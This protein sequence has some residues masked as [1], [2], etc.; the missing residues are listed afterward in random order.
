MDD[1]DLLLYMPGSFVCPKQ[2]LGSGTP[3]PPAEAEM[4][5]IKD[6]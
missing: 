1:I 6:S 4:I 2:I 5:D 3:N